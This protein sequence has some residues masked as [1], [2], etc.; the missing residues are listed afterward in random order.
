MLLSPVPLPGKAPSENTMAQR[1]SR[2][3]A[4]M[5]KIVTYQ[6]GTV[7]VQARTIAAFMGRQ[8]IREMGRLECWY[9]E[10]VDL[11]PRSSN[12]RSVT[13]SI[14]ENVRGFLDAHVNSGGGAGDDT[15]NAIRAALTAVVGSEGD[16][17]GKIT[18]HQRLLNVSFRRVKD[19]IV[20][21]ADLMARAAAAVPDKRGRA[22]R[23]KIVGWR[24]RTRKARSDKTGHAVIDSICDFMHSQSSPDNASKRGEV[25]VPHRMADGS[26]EMESHAPCLIADVNT[27]F[28]VLTG[29]DRTKAKV[30]SEATG[31]WDH[32]TTR[33]PDP[34][35]ALILQLN[36]R[37]VDRG[38]KP[39]KLCP[40]TLRKAACDCMGKVSGTY[41]CADKVRF[42]FE[43]VHAKY[44][45]AH[46]QWHQGK[47]CDCGCDSAKVTT[48]LASPS[49]AIDCTVCPRVH[50]PEFDLPEYDP[51]TAQ[52]TGRVRQTK[53]HPFKCLEGSCDCCGWDQAFGSC[54]VQ[55]VPIKGL[56][57]EFRA[58]NVD[59]T[60]GRQFAWHSWQR[61]PNTPPPVDNPDDPEYSPTA[62]KATYT[63]VWFPMTG[64]RA[65][66]FC[67][68]KKSFEEY[69]VHMGWIKWH[70]VCEA[71]AL[72]RLGIQ[73]ALKGPMGVEDWQRNWIFGH[74][75]FAAAIKVTRMAEATGSFAQ[76][77][78]MCTSGITH[79]WRLQLVSDLPAGKYRSGLEREGVVSYVA[80]DT[81]V[82]FAMGNSAHNAQYYGNVM[83]QAMEVLHTG[84]VPAGSQMEFYFRGERLLGSDTSR[85]LAHG[86]VDATAAV[87]P[88]IRSGHSGIPM[89]RL[90][91]DGSRYRPV[92]T[93]RGIK[94]CT[95][96]RENRDGCLAQFQALH[97]FLVY[98]LFMT[99]TAVLIVNVCC[100]AGGGKGFADGL[101]RVVSQG[102]KILAL[103]GHECGSESRGLCQ[104]VARHRSAPETPRQLKR[105]LTAVTNYL[106]CW[107]GP[108]DGSAFVDFYADAGYKG[109]RKDHL[110]VSEPK[111]WG[112]Q[113]GDRGF[114][115]TQNRPC[116][117]DPHLAGLPDQCTV[118]RLFKNLRGNH[119]IE[120]AS[121]RAARAVVRSRVTTAFVES[122]DDGTVVVVRVHA[123]EPNQHNEPYF[124]GVVMKDEDGEAD[125]KFV[126]RNEKTQTVNH[127]VVTK[128][129]WLIRFR[130]LHYC[131]AK[132]SPSK[133]LEGA[134]AYQFLPGDA[135]TVV[136][137]A[138]AVITKKAT[139][140][141][142]QELWRGK[143]H[144]WF[145]KEA[146]AAVMADGL[147]LLS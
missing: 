129:T 10:I 79:D 39:L 19:A 4:E 54:P 41:K 50:I 146:H 98:V 3:S 87:P 114:L 105:G 2:N 42:Q 123:D 9:D 75:D 112:S 64:S 69:R 36:S 94:S 38:L 20:Q 135:D 122:V 28:D 147:D 82:V 134:R 61:I 90:S 101:S 88:F 14:I 16:M 93:E 80:A 32:P 104:L 113:E 1:V 23:S 117:C 132:T 118:S 77:S 73:V 115:L 70:H 144:F 17:K 44:K 11:E 63:T 116:G 102:C 72:D 13:T 130:W 7:K 25:W 45:K 131:P 128:N 143:D 30:Y 85:P 65:E 106:Y 110:F 124:L 26:V 24:P 138:S 107:A 86:L 12:D 52:E 22:S 89:V 91:D 74:T 31:T 33:P 103:Q 99:Y 27:L 92:V 76:T 58:C 37:R 133:T 83:V 142:A 49:S 136:F 59:S 18:A 48:F 84:R 71:R 95:R 40:E 66:F 62:V 8:Q 139:V 119:E 108:P 125:E 127:T 46:P 109:S 51:L 5:A 100:Q 137:P 140:T 81:T 60:A 47:R 15:S 29:Q 56:D 35:W 43:D 57:V 141:A 53:L 68:F 121:S 145:V 126:W 96:F 97:A 34:H 78:Q 67:A 111:T 6:S 120:R 21:R 55:N